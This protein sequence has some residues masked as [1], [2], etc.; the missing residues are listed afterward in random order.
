MKVLEHWQRLKV[1]GI[2]L[3][4]Y[5]K[6]KDRVVETSSRIITI[7]LTIHAIVTVETF[8]TTEIILAIITIENIII[9]ITLLY[10]FSSCLKNCSYCSFRNYYDYRNC[11]YYCVCYKFYGYCTKLSLPLWLL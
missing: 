8:V 11:C 2:F 7:F 1:Y 5:L 3:E 10:S 9:V 4:K 6:K